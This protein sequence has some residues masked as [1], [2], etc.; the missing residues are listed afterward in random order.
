MPN[1]WQNFSKLSAAWNLL[2]PSMG[3]YFLRAFSADQPGPMVLCGVVVPASRCWVVV[4]LAHF[5]GEAGV[6]FFDAVAL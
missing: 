3:T 2:F 5:A 4:R 6:A 1:P